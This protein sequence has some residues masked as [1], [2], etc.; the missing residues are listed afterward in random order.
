MEGYI[1]PED[2][3]MTLI[4][5]V[6][7]AAAVDVRPYQYAHHQQNEIEKIV[8]DMLQAGIIQPS[9]SLYSSPALS[10]EIEGNDRI[11]STNEPPRIE[12]VPQINKLLPAFCCQLWEFNSTINSTPSVP[13]LVD[14]EVVKAEV[15]K[16]LKLLTIWN[17]LHEDPDYILKFSIH[18]GTLQYKGKVF[19]IRT[20]VCKGNYIGKVAKKRN[21]KLTPKFFGP[22]KMIEKIGQV[23]YKLE[24]PSEATIHPV[25][26]VS[27]LK[28]FVGD[29]QIIQPRPPILT[30]NFE[31]LVEPKD[32]VGFHR[33]LQTQDVELL[34]DDVRSP[35]LLKYSRRGKKG[36]TGE[37]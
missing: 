28:K 2:P 4:N 8:D 33:N 25:I 23:A 6:E 9:T 1:E 5:I 12:R 36:S 31:W 17:R 20:N 37:S 26:H 3:S 30:D 18:Q 32:I 7:G 19:Y 27:Q 24:L 29:M 22:Y 14:I 15:M 35:I 21:E 34:G 11:P 13:C 10:G 16:D